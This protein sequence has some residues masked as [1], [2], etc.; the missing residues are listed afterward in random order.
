VPFDLSIFLELFMTLNTP[1]QA[2]LCRK[3]GEE[4]AATDIAARA[5]PLGEGLSPAQL[6]SAIS[7]LREID[8]LMRYCSGMRERRPAHQRA[9]FASELG[10]GEDDLLEQETRSG[11]LKPSYVLVRDRELKAIVLAVRGTHSFKDMFTSL[12]GASKP[13]HMVSSDG[14][15]LG[16][17]HFGMLAGARWLKARLN[18][19]LQAALEENPGYALKVAGHSLGGGAAAMLTMMLREQQGAVAGATCLA[20]ACPACMTLELARSCDGY[21]TSVMNAADVVPTISPASADR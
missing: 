1:F 20:I 18:G 11:V 14:V 12:T 4:H 13:H 6:D 9:Y 7:D 17:S 8:R 5:R 15:V 19:R 3:D 16:F 2:Y 10:I 21:V